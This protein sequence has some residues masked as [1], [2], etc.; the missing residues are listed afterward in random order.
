MTDKETNEKIRRD[1][2]DGEKLINKFRFVLA[3]I[4]IFS[5]ILVSFIRK[6]NGLEHFPLRAYSFTGGF[7]IFSCFLYFYIRRKETLPSYFK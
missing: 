1:E 2:Y 5:I 4:F 6:A 7:L 3:L